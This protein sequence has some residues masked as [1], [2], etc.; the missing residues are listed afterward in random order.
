[1][2]N[3]FRLSL[4]LNSLCL[5]LSLFYS[6]LSAQ[7]DIQ[8]S[9]QRHLIEARD[10][11]V[12]ELP[13]GVFQLRASLWVDDKNHLTI[14]GAGMDKTILNFADQISGAEGI[15]ITNSRNITL[16][17]LTVQNAK[18]DGVKTQEVDGITLRRVKAEWTRGPHKSNGGYGLYPVQ[19]RNVLVDACVSVGASDAGIYVGQSHTIIVKNCRAWQN[20]TGIEIENSMHADVYGNEVTDNT[21]GILVFDLPDLLVKKGGHVRVFN[22]YIHHNNHINFAPK[23]NIVAKVPLGTGVMILATN[24]VDVFANKIIGHKTIGTAIVSYYMTENPIQDTTYY[25]YPSQVSIYD[26]LYE[27]ERER[28][29]MRGRMGKM[30]RFKLRFGKDVPHIIYDGIV[31]QKRP[32]EICIR[33]NQNQTF[34][35]IDAENGFKNIRQDLGP[36]DCTLPHLPPVSLEY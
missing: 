17:D 27:R 30:F 25:P 7:D 14:R 29:T 35:N 4:S 11:S 1:M 8:K 9:F 23:G 15:K 22:N 13:A 31:D 28:A 36:H 2:V 34:A 33:Q 20:V 18:G 32:A 3:P 16:E 10:S 5:S 12:I 21:A 19:C 6:T 26:N 24:H